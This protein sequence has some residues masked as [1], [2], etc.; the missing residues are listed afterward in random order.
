MLHW[1]GRLLDGCL[2]HVGTAARVHAR[3]LKDRFAVAYWGR[4]GFDP[5]AHQPL[6]CGD[7]Q[8]E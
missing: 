3:Q 2:V 5:E 6:D 7:R 8:Q 1:R 4:L